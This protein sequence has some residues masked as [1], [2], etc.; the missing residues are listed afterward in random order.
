MPV[1]S[2][3]RSLQV[4]MAAFLLAVPV[5]LTASG[6][7]AQGSAGDSRSRIGSGGRSVTTTTVT[8]DPDD[9]AGALDLA[10]VEHRIRQAHGAVR[11]R[12][13]V[14]TQHGFDPATLQHRHRRFT[15]ELDTD[16]EPGAERNVR[17]VASRTGVVAEVVSNATRDVVARLSTSRPDRR[18]LAFTGN[19]EEVGAR[20]YFWY[21]DFHARGSRG[22][23]R[24]DG[25][26]VICQDSAPERGWI[27][28]DSPAWPTTPSRTR[29]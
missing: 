26:A 28:L 29:W 3:R 12:W 13:T 16:G 10:A 2:R 21:S 25:F 1:H 9:T 23:G 8:T 22:C 15:V 18:S 20:R 4:A 5:L 27:R 19:P 11:V 14:R 24:D 17:L 7:T 6:P